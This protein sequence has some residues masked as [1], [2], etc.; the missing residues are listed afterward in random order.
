[1]SEGIS[2]CRYADD[3]HIFTQSEDEA[4][5]ALYKL[6]EK[7]LTNEGLSLQRG[8]TRLLTAKE[9]VSTRPLAHTDD[10]AAER[11]F[12]AFS[13]RFDPYSPSAVEDYAVLKAQ[14]EHFDISGMLTRELNKTRVHPAL[15]RRLIRALRFMD[16]L[17]RDNAV[18]S[19]IENLP[20]LAPVF[21]DVMRALRLLFEELSS[22]VQES[23]S[24]R[25]RLMFETES[26][27]VRAE[28]NR[29]YALRVLALDRSAENEELFARMYGYAGQIIK[30]DIVL[31]MAR[32]NVAYWVSDRLH[33]FYQEQPWVQRA[34]LI[35][36]YC[37]GDEGRHW[38]QAI[39]PG[40]AEYEKLLKV[41]VSQRVQHAGWSV[42]L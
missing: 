41:W 18:L 2:F 16:P 25:L 42:P 6:S 40:L 12:I 32:W 15:T 11:E 5:D 7:L 27:L 26:F 13:W 14:V 31:A 37:L 36:S 38:R 23:I 22:S 19:L 3:Y 24:E 29:A 33:Y 39:S 28:V 34:L 17:P 10:G 21:T 20:T 8:K 30:H 4:H 1:M 9:F 35:A